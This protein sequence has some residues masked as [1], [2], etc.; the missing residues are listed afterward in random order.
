MPIE[1]FLEAEILGEAAGFVRAA[2]V[3]PEFT[4]R[5]FSVGRLESLI[6]VIFNIF[7]FLGWV[8]KIVSARN[9]TVGR[10]PTR[11]ASDRLFGWGNLLG[12][13]GF[14]DTS[15]QGVSLHLGQS[16]TLASDLAVDSFPG[17]RS[18]SI[19]ARDVDARARLDA[20]VFVF[21]FHE[22]DA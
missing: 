6:L 9:R 12:L 5:G 3:L 13:V 1:T 18:G 15:R 20:G 14:L 21:G 10:N 19:F 17:V 4:E 11:S 2:E 22:L 8:E 16:A 7:R